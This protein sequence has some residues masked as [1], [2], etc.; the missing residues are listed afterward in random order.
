VQVSHHFDELGWDPTPLQYHHQCLAVNAVERL[1]EVHK[2]Y[3]QLALA[4]C[5]FIEKET[6]GEELVTAST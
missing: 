1:L 3:H 2:H 6:Q 5:C 4:L